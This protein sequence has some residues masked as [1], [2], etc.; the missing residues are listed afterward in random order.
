M[1]GTIAAVAKY[2][3]IKL[4]FDAVKKANEVLD[5]I[6]KLKEELETCTSESRKIEIRKEILNLSR[7][8]AKN[9]VIS[10]GAALKF[11]GAVAV[12]GA[13]CYALPI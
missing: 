13:V 6:N 7:E 8:E 2:Q 4:Y 1:C 12:A 9:Q 3:D 5:E 10:A 11:G